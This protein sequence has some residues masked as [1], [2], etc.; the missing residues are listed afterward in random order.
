MKYVRHLVVVGVMALTASMCIN[1]T[2]RC[3]CIDMI[4]IS[5]QNPRDRSHRT[6]HSV[7]QR[8]DHTVQSLQNFT[9]VRIARNEE[10]I[11]QRRNLLNDQSAHQP[12][13][14]SSRMDHI[15]RLKPWQERIIVAVFVIRFLSTLASAA[16]ASSIGRAAMAWRL[17][18][19]Y[20]I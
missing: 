12:P 10:K 15:R 1:K 16:F 4:Q 19:L 11:K 13:R 9:T 8:I 5:K 18:H 6:R 3:L 20:V 2:R 14:R 17:R 7:Q